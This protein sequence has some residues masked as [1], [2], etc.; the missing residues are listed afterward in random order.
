MINNETKKGSI[1]IHCTN[2]RFASFLGGLVV[3]Y[4]ILGG[5]I[6]DAIESRYE[7]AR[8]EEKERNRYY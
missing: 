2:L 7:L 1:D 8:L 6:F 5:L 3:G 4:V